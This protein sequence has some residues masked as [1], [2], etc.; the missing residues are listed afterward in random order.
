[1]FQV[2][3]SVDRLTQ[4][5][6]FENLLKLDQTLLPKENLILMDCSTSVK[7]YKSYGGQQVFVS[8]VQT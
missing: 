4:S 1:M 5:E 3:F 2:R 6:I 7:I 8:R